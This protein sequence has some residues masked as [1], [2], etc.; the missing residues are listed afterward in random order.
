M[1]NFFRNVGVFALACFSFFVTDE[2]V[3]VVKESDYL[4][5]IIK[6]KKSEYYVASIPGEINGEY[7]KLGLSG[8]ELNLEKSYEQMKKIGYF[9]ESLIVYNYIKPENSLKDN[10]DKIIYANSKNEV[11]L[12]IKKPKNLE[13]ILQTLTSYNLQASFLIDK[14]YFEDNQKLLL[15]A[16][17]RDNSLIIMDEPNFFKRELKGHNYYCYSELKCSKQKVEASFSINSFKELKTNLKKGSLIFVSN[18]DYLD[19]YLKYILSR[20]L[21]IVNMDTFIKEE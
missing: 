19:I 9:N 20:G 21:T 8:M 2:T 7:L 4:M 11:S 18:H 14:S 6:A 15:K 10:K 3:S 17:S 16:L 13:N 12:I 5:T 1:K